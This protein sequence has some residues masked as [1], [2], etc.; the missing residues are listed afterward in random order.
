[1]EDDQGPSDQPTKKGRK[2]MLLAAL[3]VAA[4][5]ADLLRIFIGC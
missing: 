2:D 3:S 5:L 1:M 4:I